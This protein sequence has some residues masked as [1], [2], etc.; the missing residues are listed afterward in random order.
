[1]K[2][3]DEVRV[4]VISGKGGDGCGAFRREK[5]VPRGGPSGGNGGRG[6]HI[7]FRASRHFNTLHSL[8][9]TPIIRAKPGTA[10]GPNLRTGAQGQDRV[11]EVP[12]GTLIRRRGSQ[13]VLA[14]LQDEGVEFLAIE[15]GNGG[16]G[17]AS[18]K[19]S[20]HRAPTRFEVG[21]PSREAELQLELKL[22]AD[23]GLL[24]FPNAGKSTLIST[25]SAARPKVASY[26]FTTLA[27]SL[28]VVQV[29]EDYS[30]FV[31]ADIPG[32]IE[33]AAE[34]A[35]LGHRF[36]RH[37]ERCRILLHM[38]SLD[39][40]EVEANG[41]VQERFEK[42]N[43]ELARYSPE[44]GARQQVVLLSKLDVAEADVVAEASS[45]F[46]DQGLPV[47]TGSAVT[48]AGMKELVSAIAQSIAAADSPAD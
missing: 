39:P 15:G 43:Q 16:R 10:G 19:S 36:L 40:F 20:T 47:L 13:K 27:P 2:F 45:W 3:I 35:G 31:M 9:F 34:G 48:G 11:V 44:L 26:P 42:M 12:V 6:G 21:G 38:V 14:D 33:G 46:R 41:T 29:A 28:G 37:V 32:L 4:T 7:I 22:L 18:F 17:N 5:F 30:T 8:R 25:L 24:G 23:V 1:V